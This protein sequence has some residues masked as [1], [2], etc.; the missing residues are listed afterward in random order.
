MAYSV[1]GRT[2]TKIGVVGSGQIGPDIALYFSKVLAEHGVQVVVTDIS[3]QALEA[4][5]AKTRKK[6][7]K[8]VESGAFKKDQAD[9]VFANLRFS[10]DA[11]AL[12]G[13]EFVVEA[14]TE[15][16]TIKRDIFSRLEAQVAPGAILA[17]NSS[18]LEPET[19]F[20]TL[21]DPKR[22]IVI[23][24][25]FPAE[26]NPVVEVVPGKNTDPAVAEFCMRFYEAIGKVPIRVGS[27]YGYAIDPVFEGLFQ[28]A[29]QIVEEGIASPKQVDAIACKV[30]GL[31][32]GP[33]T[34]MNLTGGNPITQVGLTH[35]RE[36]IMPWFRSPGLLDRQ[37]EKKE[38]WEAAGRGERV[39]YDDGQYERVSARLT[40]A[41]FGLVCE[42]LDSGI[43]NLPDL[44]MG[45]ELALA[46]NGPFAMM[47]RIGVGEALARVQAFAAANPGFKVAGVLERQAAAGEP[48]KIRS[49]LREDRDGIAQVT[50]RRPR[51]LNALDRETFAQIAETFET[52]R[53]DPTVQAAVLTGFGVKAFVSGAD[54]GMLATIQGPADG[55]ALCRETGRAVQAVDRVGKPVVCAMNGLALGGGNEIAMA[56]TARIARKGQKMFVG[57]PEVKLG[58]IPGAGGTQRL[59]RLIPFEKAWTL[60]RTGGSLSSA[61]S[62][63]LGLI[64]EEVEG[65][66]LARATELAR[67]LA[68]GKVQ[69]P[70]IPRG[71]IPVPAHPPEVDLAGFSR[72]IDEILRRT[73]LEG[74]GMTLEQGVELEIRSFGECCATRDMKI[75]IENF[76]KTNLKEPAKF[77]HA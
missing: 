65:D 27:R 68:S 34:A 55:E 77:V 15:R 9:R 1:F 26:R 6:L 60:L 50:I 75:G 33:F 28:A 32:V 37:L 13:A 7:D 16:D 62:L 48:W 54:I 66:L 40:G 53:R 19:I 76:Q 11:S 46:M 36:K 8:G 74:A 69:A 20:P 42:V 10:P 56:C 73:I 5:A 64:R 58:F 71:P 21:Q 45:I 3:P 35:Y 14:A 67:D 63:Q 41:C 17:S 12:A 52:I 25:F 51:V 4:G 49:V 70:P 29:T 38:P 61:E 44:E 59:P 18:H 43:S 24:Y 47:N 31:G 30:L 72:R 23:H 22:G 39:Q 2:L 57:Q